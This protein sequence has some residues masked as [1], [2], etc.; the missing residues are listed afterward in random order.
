MGRYFMSELPFYSFTLHR[1][2]KF[3]RWGMLMAT[4]LLSA[5]LGV[6]AVELRS[7]EPAYVVARPVT[8]LER[9]VTDR[10]TDYISKVL[11]TPA[12]VVADL[13]TVPAGAPAIILST[14]GLGLSADLAVPADSPEGF[15]LETRR[16]DG[17]ALIIAAGQTDRGLK[18][19]VQRLVIR[20]EQRA[21]A[22]PR[23]GRLPPR[24]GPRRP[25]RDRWLPLNLG[26]S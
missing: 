24:V 12:R 4:A 11:G 5:S 2:F 13:A 16:L 6:A 1:F 8:A 20:S 17:H 7:G 3:W 23:S 21:H 19:A 15:A 10:L 14:N 18:R 25:V 22:I 9:R 26:Q